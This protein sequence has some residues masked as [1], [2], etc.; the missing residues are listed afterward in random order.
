MKS[1][2]VAVKPREAEKARRALAGAGL[3]ARGLRASKSGG[4]VLFPVTDAAAA[5]GLLA[6]I[7]IRAEPCEAEFPEARRGPP[8]PREEGLPGYW[9][10]GGILVF[11]PRGVYDEERLRRYAERLVASRAAKAAWVKEG[12]WGVY[13]L[14]RLRHLAGERTTKTTAREYGLVFHVDLALAYYNPKLAYEHRRVALAAADGEEMLDMFSGVGGFSIHAAAVRRVRVTAVDLNPWAASL[15]AAN[16]RANRRRLRGEVA[17]MR[18]DASLLPDLLEPVFD[19]IV[20]NHPTGSLRFA[21]VACSLAGTRKP[22]VHVYLLA[23]GPEEATA[24]AAAAFRDAGCRPLSAAPR[25]VLD[26]A[27]REY[28]YAVD[29]VLEKA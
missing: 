28:V 1:P 25:R 13:R 18:A 23:G 11:S 3:L 27:P 21:R 7:G 20:M 14:P 10:V 16:V 22:V 24:K 5:V 2:C 4:R 17:V 9:L 12:T 6:G 29:L 26:H 8:S 19:R 15:A